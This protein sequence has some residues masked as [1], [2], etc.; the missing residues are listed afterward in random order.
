MY[1]YARSNPCFSIFAEF[2]F[3]LVS[4]ILGGMSLF[5]QRLVGGLVGSRSGFLASS[6]FRV[7]VYGGFGRNATFVRGSTFVREACCHAGFGHIYT[8]LECF[9][10][11]GTLDPLG[12]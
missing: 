5:F 4:N 6:C 2:S 11:V 1:V 10:Y 9:D 7:P 12:M 8:S 3:R